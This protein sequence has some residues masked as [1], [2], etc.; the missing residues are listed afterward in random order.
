MQKILL[1]D[2][3]VEF[4]KLIAE[5]LST[6]GVTLE[7]AHSGES[8]LLLLEN[9]RPD[10]ILLD[11][12]MPGISGTDVCQMIRKDSAFKDIPIIFLTAK[13]DRQH[14][15]KAFEAGCWDYVTKPYDRRVLHARIGSA[16]KNQRLLKTLKRRVLTDSL[17]GLNNR[18]AFYE[19]AERAIAKCTENGTR[20]A[21]VFIDLDRFKWIND[22][23]G[24]EAGA[25]IL[26]HVANVLNDA[27]S[28]YVNRY[29][30]Q[31]TGKLDRTCIARMG[32]DEFLILLDEMK[33]V[34]MAVDLAKE[35]VNAL[36]SPL[37]LGGKE[38]VFGASAGIAMM[39]AEL[40]DLDQIIFQADTAMYESKRRGR[41]KVSVFDAS[42]S[43]DLRHA[44]ELEKALSDAI[45]TDEIFA[46][47]QP[48]ISLQNGQ[49]TGVES[50]ARWER[51][52]KEVVGPETFIR[53]AEET[54][55]INSLTERL[56]KQ[57]CMFFNHWAGAEPRLKEV[58]LFINISMVYLRNPDF[59]TSFSAIVEACG[60]E[61]SRIVVEI[62]Y[63]NSGADEDLLVKHLK[64]LKARGFL[65]A[66][67][68]FGSEKTS[69][70]MLTKHAVDYVKIDPMFVEKMLEDRK[71]LAIVK[72]IID[73]S[74]S[75]DIQVI[76]E[77]VEHIDQATR[78][79]VLNCDMAQGYC[80][81]GPLTEKQ[82]KKYYEEKF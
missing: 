57:S 35:I 11:N 30:P 69:L 39:D 45:G 53:I 58:K 36:A 12:E 49:I 29:F 41:G 70:G 78:I 42:M 81:S 19:K 77:G 66:L 40:A 82:V 25:Q 10:L 62:S 24:H 80:F 32:G 79:Q 33:L 61:A 34:G 50:L 9:C 7:I 4:C 27:V 59:V 64:G 15:L 52:G 31:D 1:I 8:G 48:I 16:L 55:L 22:Y 20:G 3:S 6:F 56:V 43:R 13:T 17:T 21:V 46:C 76:G 26:K 47:Y 72:S 18:V 5:S 73:L 65:V 67:D 23:Y 44:L 60:V 54:G 75:L 37:V 68:D 14:I 71:E 63:T 51:S 28:A 74:H 2:D 38:I